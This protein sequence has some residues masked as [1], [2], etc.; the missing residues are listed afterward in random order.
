M[1][2]YDVNQL[3][4][5]FGDFCDGTPA[6]AQTTILGWNGQNYVVR[7]QYYAPAQYRFQA[8]QD[9]DANLFSKRI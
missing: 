2:M 1:V 7:Q 5:A 6:R 4:A 3:C 8:I 9:G